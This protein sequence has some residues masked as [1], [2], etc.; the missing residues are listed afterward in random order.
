M[1]QSTKNESVQTKELTSK[2]E[3]IASA[4]CQ[5]KQHKD[6]DQTNLTIAEVKVSDQHHN[7]KPENDQTGASSA[8]LQRSTIKSQQVQSISDRQKQF[9]L[10]CEMPSM[11]CHRWHEDHKK[12]RQKQTLSVDMRQNLHPTI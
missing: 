12:D 9:R 6:P 10:H 1:S 4:N 2:T 3:R 8:S 11:S 5:S 7:K